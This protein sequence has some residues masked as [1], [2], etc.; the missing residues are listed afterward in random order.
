MIVLQ[1]ISRIV[2]YCRRYHHSQVYLRLAACAVLASALPS[3][4]FAA[5]TIV[6]MEI[7]YGTNQGTV[8]IELYDDQAP[9]TVANFLRY[10]GRGDYNNSIIHRNVPGF[11]I[12]GGG[13]TY[14]PN[15][16]TGQP[17]FFKIP[18]DAPIQN[19]FSPSRSNIRGTI[20]MAKLG[21]NPNSATSEWFFNLS[22]TNA[23]NLDYQNGGFTVFGRVLTPAPGTG[24]DVVDAIADPQTQK[25]FDGANNYPFYYPCN[26]NPIN[27][28]CTN[29]T[30]FLELPTVSYDPK[31]YI[32]GDSTTYLQ[33]SNLIL[34]IR[35]PNVASIRTPLGTWTI[36][37]ADVDMTFSPGSFGTFN[38]AAS[39]ALLATFTPPANA[40]LQFNDGIFTFTMAGTMGPGRIVTMYDGAATR[41]THYYAYG[42]TPDNTAPHWYDFSYDGETGAEISGDKI[43]LHFVDGK[44]GDDDLDDTN[45][46]VTHI[47]APAVVT[48]GATTSSSSGSSSGS[49]GRSIA[50]KPSQTIGNG[51][52]VVVSLFLAFVALVRKRTRR[53][54]NPRA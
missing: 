22:D 9:I 47:G 43:T 11:I 28:A 40:T 14:L 48:A 19:E 31:S 6:R 15:P 3:P 30:Y 23:A 52:W 45:G 12:Q 29:P 2:F 42:R 50:A 46:S 54:R 39:A 24:M 16:F 20:T 41:P 1:A 33:A 44:R 8:D 26:P 7:T 27:F 13:H 17:V 18:A 32:D 25:I 49:S 10:A 21:G 34:V 4:L 35:I 53:D 5:N 51:D 38:A 37:T 36:F